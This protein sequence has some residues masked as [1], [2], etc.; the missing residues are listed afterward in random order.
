MV[1]A[2][3]ERFDN[4]DIL[5]LPIENDEKFIPSDGGTVPSDDGTDGLVNTRTR[6]SIP[7]NLQKVVGAIANGFSEE[8]EKLNK[9]LNPNKIEMDISLGFSEKSDAWIVGVRGEQKV[10]IKF[11][12]EKGAG[13]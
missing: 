3:K 12:W 10:S 11:T 4:V 9:R 1:G 6:T 2:K 5:F 7:A 8:F 13:N